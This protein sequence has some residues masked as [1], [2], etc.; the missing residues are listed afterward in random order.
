[1]PNCTGSAACSS[2]VWVLMKPELRLRFA[3]LSAQQRSRSRFRWRN[4]RKHPA[5]NTAAEKGI[6]RPCSGTLSPAIF[7]TARAISR[8][9]VEHL[10]SRLTPTNT[11]KATVSVGTQPRNVTITPD[12]TS[13]YVAN[14]TSNSVSVID[15]A[16]NTV[17]ATILVGAKPRRVGITPDG[18]NAYV[19]AAGSNSVSVISIGTKTVTTTTAVGT[20]PQDAAAF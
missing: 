6:A 12:G 3:Q 4:A 16:T 19:P 20:N 15:T 2:R 8:T 11:G 13:A 17:T 9:E 7:H 10:G 1:V 18:A 14:D 5:Q